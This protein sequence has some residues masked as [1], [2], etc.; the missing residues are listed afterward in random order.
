[1]FLS[2]GIK[3]W[4]ASN[5]HAVINASLSPSRLAEDLVILIE[6]AFK[7]DQMNLPSIEVPNRFQ[8]VF[9]KCNLIIIPSGHHNGLPSPS[10]I[11]LEHNKK[12]KL[13]SKAI[14]IKNKTKRNTSKG[15]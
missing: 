6:E 1:M 13:I 5:Q 9:L 4:S 8:P 14:A 10:V 11:I 3:N 2:P 15:Q 7:A 12:I